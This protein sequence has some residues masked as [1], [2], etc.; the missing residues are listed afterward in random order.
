MTLIYKNLKSYAAV[1]S[2]ND[3]ENAGTDP[4]KAES[5]SGPV[6]GAFGQ[7]PHEVVSAGLLGPGFRQSRLY[8]QR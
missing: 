5:E 8:I 2:T 7:H 1:L 6:G 4:E 3:L